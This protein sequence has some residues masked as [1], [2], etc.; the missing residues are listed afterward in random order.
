MPLHVLAIHIRFSDFHDRL[1]QLETGQP[2]SQIIPRRNYM[3]ACRI[4]FVFIV[5]Y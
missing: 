4:S 3:H 5:Q 2:V 1:K